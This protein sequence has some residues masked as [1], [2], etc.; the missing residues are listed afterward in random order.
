MFDFRFQKW[1]KFRLMEPQSGLNFG[2]FKKFPSLVPFSKEKRKIPDKLKKLAGTSPQS[3][4]RFWFPIQYSI[5]NAAT[6]LETL[7]LQVR[8][9]PKKTS[10][11]RFC[12]YMLAM[13]VL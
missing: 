1:R 10:P 4:F 9:R 13:L 2:R 6:N 7:S 11:K 12:I 5:S 8:I 3:N